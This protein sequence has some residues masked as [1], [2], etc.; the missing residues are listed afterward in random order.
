M[1]RDLFPSQTRAHDSVIIGKH[2]NYFAAAKFE[3]KDNNRVPS[4]QEIRPDPTQ[5]SQ[6]G[7]RGKTLLCL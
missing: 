5:P 1:S 7:A 6:I 2:G 4:Q 3:K